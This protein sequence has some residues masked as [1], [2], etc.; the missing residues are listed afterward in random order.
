MCKI[1]ILATN[2]EDTTRLYL[3]KEVRDIFECLRQ[4][5]YGDAFQVKQRW[6]VR[7]RHLQQ[8][9][10]E[11]LPQIVHFSGHGGGDA[12]LYF[13]DNDDNAKS[14]T[15]EALASLF[16]LIS[17][18]SPINCVLLNGCYSKV[19]AEAIV[20]YVPYVIGMN[21]SIGEQAAI[22]FAVGFY[23]ALGNGE[24]VEFAFE[25][26]KVEMELHSTG[27]YTVPVLL[28]GQ[29]Q[30]QISTDSASKHIPTQ[31][32]SPH[33]LPRSG[34]ESDKFIG[35]VDEVFWLQNRLKQHDQVEISALSGMGGIGKT[36]LSLRYALANQ[37]D[38]SGGICWI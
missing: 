2:P 10:L 19:Q 17:Q 5:N 28:K 18:K 31:V 36:E 4:T 26:G 27:D 22:E 38:Y 34:I 14:V 25:S 1:L 21:A 30:E 23:R 24:S 32:S 12:G 3:D 11:E 6:A 33:N 15:G 9:V 16:R 20:E 8:A 29:T 35:R 7:L 13:H 37:N